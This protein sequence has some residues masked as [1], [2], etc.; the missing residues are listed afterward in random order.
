MI[1]V[2]V[3]WLKFSVMTQGSISLV[4]VAVLAARAI[5]IA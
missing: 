5:N 1:V 4:I 2:V 3:N